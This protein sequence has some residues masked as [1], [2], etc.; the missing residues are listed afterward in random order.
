[1]RK[2]ERIILALLCVLCLLTVTG[3]TAAP[4]IRAIRSAMGRI[5]QGSFAMMGEYLLIPNDCSGFELQFRPDLPRKILDEIIPGIQTPEADRETGMIRCPLDEETTCW[6]LGNAY[7]FSIGPDDSI[8][9][10]IYFSDQSLMFVQHKKTLV[11][12]AQSSGRGVP[13]ADGALQST[14]AHKLKISSEPSEGEVRWSPDSHYLFFNDTD[15]WSGVG[16]TLDDPYLMD[17]QTGEIF[18]LDNGGSPKDPLRGTFRCVLN[19]RFSMDGKSFYWYCRSYV[20]G[21]EPA[22]SIM[23]YS[24][25]DG[26]QETVYT[27]EGA[28]QDFC[29]VKEN[30]WFLLETADSG[31]NLIRM[32]VSKNR[33]DMPKELIPIPWKNCSFLP[34]IRENVL[35]AVTPNTSG[36]TYMLPLTWDTPAAAA[37]CKIGSLEEGRMR[38]ISIDEIAAEVQEAKLNS[39]GVTANAAISAAN[40]KHAAAITGVTDLLLTIFIREPVPDSWG[41]GFRDFNSQVILN[42]ETLALFPIRNTGVPDGFRDSLIDGTCFLP[43]NYYGQT[44]LGLYFADVLPEITFRKGESFTSP[45][46]VFMCR[47]ESDPLVFSSVTLENR[48]CAADITALETGY[49]IRFSI[50]DYPEPEIIRKEFTVPE[51]LTVDRWDELKS[52]MSKK[53]QKKLSAL[54]TKIVPGKLDKRKNQDEILAAYPSAATE[55]LYVLIDDAKAVNLEMAEEIL[56]AAGYTAED[57]AC[58]MELAAVPRETNIIVTRNGQNQTFPVRYAFSASD[59]LLFPKS[60]RIEELA[61]LCERIC[62]AVTANLDSEAPVAVEDVILDKYDMGSVDFYVT[63]DHSE[64]TDSALEIFLTVVP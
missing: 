5:E 24:L 15:R 4:D 25:A 58:D 64:A 14:L 22:H 48:E 37:W 54:F 61:G 28:L 30:C 16:I 21:D 49:S 51:V 40:I 26:T 10:I 20:S 39:N 50:T 47:N 36:G 41:G 63:L 18:L 45:F 43:K 62:K 12:A 7:A 11:L 23:R 9:W 17:T 1:M 52:A 35:L 33:A 32:D 13:D 31:M 42:T 53:D 19:G 46:G 34:A 56:E 3:A 57:Y 27:L 59:P 8:L 29:E 38:E 44:A 2:K 55:T 6:L 60:Y